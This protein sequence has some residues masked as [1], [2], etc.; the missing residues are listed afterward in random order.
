MDNFVLVFHP[1]GKEQHTQLI[2]FHDIHAVMLAFKDMGR[3]GMGA[4][5]YGLN[6]PACLQIAEYNNAR[7]D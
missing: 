5:V 3:N 1:P 4:C 7:D 6:K 2:H